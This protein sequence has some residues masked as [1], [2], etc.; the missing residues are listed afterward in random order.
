[1]DGQTGLSFRTRQQFV[2]FSEYIRESTLWYI[3]LF[4]GMSLFESAF[5]NSPSIR[6]PN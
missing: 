5:G 1:M 6:L 3:A 4:S 2:S